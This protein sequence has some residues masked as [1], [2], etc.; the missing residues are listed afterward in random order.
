MRVAIVGFGAEGQA[1]YRYWH[2]HTV[3]V[4]DSREDI[5]VPAD[6]YPQLGS[7]YLCGLDGYDRIVRS[8]GVRPDLI[9]AA[10]PGLKPSQI[11]TVSNEFFRV[12]PTSNI[13]GVTGTKGK[14]TTSTLIAHILTAAGHTVHLGGNIGTPALDLLPAIEEH[15]WVV[16]ELSSFQLL[17][18]NHSPHIGVCLRITPDHLDYHASMEEYVT[19]KGNIFAHQADTD[20]AVFHRDNDHSRQL[21]AHSPGRQLDYSHT[22]GAYATVADNAIWVDG[23]RVCD[24]AVVGLLGAHNLENVTAAAAATYPIVGEVA[25]LAEA[26]ESFHGL[27]HRLQLVAE[28][29]GVR[30]IDDSFSTTP[31]TAIAAIT[32]FTEPKTVIVGGSDKGADFSDLA[33]VIAE[34]DTRAV[35]V[36]GDTAPQIVSD[37][38]SA[39]FEGEVITDLDAMAA[40]I[41]AARQHTPRGGVVLL[42]PGC[43]S[44]G[45]FSDYKDRGR[46]FQAAVTA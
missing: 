5:A 14:G 8:P 36:I 42:S 37:L 12:V 1:A 28:M 13:I 16:M 41:H 22:Q 25:P 24:M 17:D 20:T 32:S 23:S 9:T 19:A 18:M 38:E 34:S 26:I 6:A 30:Y 46:Q 3:T 10:N 15:D 29:D 45:L 4:C 2:G 11:T 43:A 31:E 35:I 21:A 44:F 7:R 33:R 39:E 40:I 27:E